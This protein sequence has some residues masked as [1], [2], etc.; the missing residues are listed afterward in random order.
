M[1]PH[2]HVFD[3]NQALMDFGATLCTAR[4]P[5]CLICP[6]RAGCRAYPVQPRHTS[7]SEPRCIVVTAAVVERDGRYLVT[8]RLRG[9]HLEGCGSFRAASASRARSLADCLRREIREELGCAVRSARNCFTVTHDYPERTR[10]AALLSLRR[11]G[12][13]PRP[14]L[15][16]EMRWVARDELRTLEFPARGRRADSPAGAVNGS[17]TTVT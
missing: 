3:F 17:V 13:E 4:K 6:M 10:R 2:R 7:V 15:G 1:L 16:Q 8:R 11:L 5:K 9:T 12:A 14:L